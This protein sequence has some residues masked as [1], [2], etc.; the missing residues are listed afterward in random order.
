MIDL[1]L[2]SFLSW[3]FL[4]RTKAAWEPYEPVS[5]SER[6]AQRTGHACITFENKIIMC[7]ISIL[8]NQ[9]GCTDIYFRFYSVSVA[10]TVSIITMI[11]GHSISPPEDGQSC[12]ASDSFR[13]L[14]KVTQLH[15][16][17]MLYIF[18]EAEAWMVKI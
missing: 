3:R 13:R 6:P 17:M 8:V 12:N 9:I 4:V 7:C 11:H 1:I 14:E 10:L 2:I 15:W 16:L 5:G 18:L